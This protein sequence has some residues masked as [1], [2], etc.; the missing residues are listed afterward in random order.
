MKRK[1][2]RTRYA[3]HA[4][5]A[6]WIARNIRIRKSRIEFGGGGAFVMVAAK[7]GSLLGYYRGSRVK[8]SELD[9]DQKDYVMDGESGGRCAYD[10]DGRLRLADSRIVDVHKW[11]SEDWKSLKCDGVEWISTTANW[12]RFINHA[13]GSYRNASICATSECFGRSRVLER[14]I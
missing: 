9:E 11:T 1:S 5:T 2:K 6:E 4:L 8:Y 12:T 3:E 7:R 13:S 10:P 14:E